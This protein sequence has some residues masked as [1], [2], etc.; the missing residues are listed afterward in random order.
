MTTAGIIANPASGKDIRRLVAHGSSFDNNEKINLVRRALTGLDAAGVDRVVFMP[1][2][3]AIVERAAGPLQLRL[4]LSPLVMPILG[5]AGDSLEAAR[6]MID[7]GA[8]V[9]ITLG[10]DGTN[11]VVAKAGG[12]VPLVAISTGTN[13][14]F[15][16]MVEGT[17]AGLA[18]G[19]VATG[20]A[21][22]RP[23]GPRVVRRLPKLVV[24]IDGTHR[25]LALIDVVATRQSWIGSRA[26]WDPDQIREVVLSRLEPAAIGLASLGGLLFPAACGGCSGAHVVVGDHESGRAVL[27]PLAPGL[28]RQ[29]PIEEARLIEHG[30]EVTLGHGPCLIALDGERELEVLDPTASITVAFSPRGPRVVDIAAA[31][32]DGASQGFF[33]ASSWLPGD[34]T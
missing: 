10:G 15:P 8:G 29:V 31:I 27:A 32:Q 18:A 11:R 34:T 1:D 16:T 33:A 25:D 5:E 24:N 26:L 14:V 21:R 23:G 3:Y 20:I 4:Q 22:N 13:N 9:I 2:P 7:L 17:L 28:I 12:E 30:E 6:R 19:L